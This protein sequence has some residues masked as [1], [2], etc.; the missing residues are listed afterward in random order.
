M[1][2]GESHNSRNDV[3]LRVKDTGW[4]TDRVY[5]TGGAILVPGE[6][7]QA[8]TRRRSCSYV[9]D[10]TRGGRSLGRKAPAGR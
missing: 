6:N 7:A 2:D 10:E 4:R 9:E 5:D 1:F 8:A 3:G